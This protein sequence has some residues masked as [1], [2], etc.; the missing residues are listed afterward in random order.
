[1]AGNCIAG[2]EV[3]KEERK[4]HRVRIQSLLFAQGIPVKVGAKFLARLGHLAHLG[5][6]TGTGA[7]EATHPG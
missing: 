3:L 2:W 5:W 6:S 7:T 1:M 4:Q